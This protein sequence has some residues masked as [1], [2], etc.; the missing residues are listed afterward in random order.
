MRELQC[1][2][3]NKRQETSCEGGCLKNMAMGAGT[4]ASKERVK[5]KCDE[6]RPMEYQCQS[7]VLLLNTTRA[8]LPIQIDRC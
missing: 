3:E 2:P 8:L 5:R 4:V 7:S 6:V 1:M